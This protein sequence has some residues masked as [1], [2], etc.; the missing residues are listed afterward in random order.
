MVIECQDNRSQH[1]NKAKALA[2][3]AVR[4]KE[5]ELEK[6][7]ASIAFERK[8]LVG[9]GDRSEKIR[10]YNFPQVIELN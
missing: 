5:K 6:Q 2:L 3:L 4:L 7:E 8:N 1:K 10:A 9:S